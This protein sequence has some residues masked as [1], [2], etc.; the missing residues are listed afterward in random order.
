MFTYI[1]NANQKTTLADLLLSRRHISATTSAQVPPLTSRD[2]LKL[3]P[4][5]PSRHMKKQLKNFL[6]SLPKTKDRQLL[7]GQET[8]KEKWNNLA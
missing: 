7:H 1:N 4:L 6:T 3:I 8:R 2:R 5:K